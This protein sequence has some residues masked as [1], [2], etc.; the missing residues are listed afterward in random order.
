M[1]KLRNSLDDY[2]KKKQETNTIINNY[3]IKNNKYKKKIELMKQRID[4]L[5]EKKELYR[6]NHQYNNMMRFNSTSNFFHP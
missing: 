2:N 6:L 1:Q 4:E 3:M 5:L